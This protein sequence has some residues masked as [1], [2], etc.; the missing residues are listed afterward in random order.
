MQSLTVPLNPYCIWEQGGPSGAP[1]NAYLYNPAKG[2]VLDINSS[3][4]T[5]TD[6]T[7]INMQGYYTNPLQTYEWWSSTQTDEQY[8][9]ISPFN[10]SALYINAYT[11]PHVPPALTSWSTGSTKPQMSWAFIP[12]S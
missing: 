7:P 6:P 1:T 12:V 11:D 9:S 2:L 4:A 5:L 10:A 3:S 8:L